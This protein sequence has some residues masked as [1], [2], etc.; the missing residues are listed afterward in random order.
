MTRLLFIFLSLALFAGCRPRQVN[1]PVFTFD[2]AKE[3]AIAARL[4]QQ[5]TGG[6][7][8]EIQPTGSMLPLLQA[9]DW[10]VLDARE[11]FGKRLLGHVVTYR[12]AWWRPADAPPVTHRLVEFDAH[13][14][15][16]EGDATRGG[17]SSYRITDKN[18]LG[19]VAGI[20]RLKP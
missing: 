20:Y 7:M 11:P 19:E 8:F 9:G 17:E 3:R 4:H 2:S 13:G 16:A 18:W 1:P 12:A 6:L 5:D 14:A 10:I 15:I